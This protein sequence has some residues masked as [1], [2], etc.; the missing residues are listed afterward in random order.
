MSDVKR[1]QVGGILPVGLSWAGFIPPPL[2]VPP[3]LPSVRRATS[4][5]E[6][7]CEPCPPHTQGLRPPTQGGD[8]QNGCH[9]PPSMRQGRVSWSVSPLPALPS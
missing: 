6:Q 8:T 3:A 2:L 7:L 5:V 1:G 4:T 9:G